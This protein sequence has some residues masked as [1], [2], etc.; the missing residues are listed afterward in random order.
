MRRADRLCA[1]AD[2]ATD[3]TLCDGAVRLH[4]R[5]SAAGMGWDQVLCRLQPRLAF[6]LYQ[7]HR[8][9]ARSRVQAGGRC[10]S[11]MRRERSIPKWVLA[12][13]PGWQAQA[14]PHHGRPPH[15]LLV[16]A[17][18]IGNHVGL[19]WICWCSEVHRW[20]R[21]PGICR[22]AGRRLKIVSGA[23]FATRRP[24]HSASAASRSSSTT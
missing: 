7:A 12:T 10:R 17:R 9:V 20:K 18:L 4:L 22:G 14:S 11:S 6:R 16:W 5:C 15:G 21:W 3:R 24:F 13:T 23:N 19:A 8:F 2:Q 1:T